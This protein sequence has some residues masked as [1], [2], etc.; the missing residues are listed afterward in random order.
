[1]RSSDELEYLS[2]DDGSTKPMDISL[3]G[4]LNGHSVGFW[5][6]SSVAYQFEA[7]QVALDDLMATN[8]KTATSDEESDLPPGTTTQEHHKVRSRSTSVEDEEEELGDR[9]KD[10]RK[11]MRAALSNSMG[12][13]I[14][15]MANSK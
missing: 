8:D 13:D 3:N 10:D 9:S 2:D 6:Q 4:S 15:S 7:S 12:Q 1:M 14:H 5:T 11:K